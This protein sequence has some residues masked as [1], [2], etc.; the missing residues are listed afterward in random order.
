MTTILWPESEARWVCAKVAGGKGRV[1][2]HGATRQPRLPVRRG[3]LGLT[4]GYS[5]PAC[6]PVL[7]AA[8]RETPSR[9]PPRSR[10]PTAPSPSCYGPRQELGPAG[11]RDGIPAPPR[12][13]R[14]ARAKQAPGLVA[15]ASNPVGGRADFLRNTPGELRFAVTPL[16]DS[17]AFAALCF[18][19]SCA[20]MRSVRQCESCADRV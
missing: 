10:Y 18:A 4:Q 20:R 3:A 12:F 14:P 9:L 7:D 19:W 11:Q 17:H 6:S 8:L 1:R 15:P 2:E 5:G 13:S 16:L